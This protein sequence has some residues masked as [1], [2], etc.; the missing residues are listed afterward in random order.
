M[1]LGPIAAT[2][3][4]C[5]PPRLYERV[6]RELPDVRTYLLKDGHLYLS[7]MVD[8]A[9]YEWVPM[10]VDATDIATDTGA[11]SDNFRTVAPDG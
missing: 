9:I 10:Q 3:A 6:A 7:L 1:R 4:L 5:T 11:L 8:G 2:H